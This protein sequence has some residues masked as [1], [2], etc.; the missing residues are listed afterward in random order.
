MIELATERADGI[1]TYFVPAEHTKRAR[2]ILGPDPMLVPEQA[3]LESDPTTARQIARSHVRRYVPLPNYT[4]NLKRLGFTDDDFANEG[5]DRLVD[6]IV[7]HRDAKAITVRVQ[8]HIDAGA[9][10]VCLQ[11]LTENRRQ[12]SIGGWRRL[13]SDLSNDELRLRR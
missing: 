6:A 1:H 11:V 7:A 12:F 13:I 4:N 3:V 2:A 8:Q 9:S 10:H 5:S